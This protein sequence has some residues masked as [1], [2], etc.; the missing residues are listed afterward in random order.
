MSRWIGA[1]ASRRGP[2]DRISEHALR[3]QRLD[4]IRNAV[5]QFTYVLGLLI[6]GHE[7][8]DESTDEAV[9]AQLRRE[10]QP[11]LDAGD[12][13]RPDFGAF[14]DLRIEGE[15]LQASQPILATLEFDD[16]S[17]RET[18]QGRVVPARGRRLRVRMH[19]AIE[20]VRIIDCAVSEVTDRRG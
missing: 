14:G 18:A 11:F 5:E 6:A 13:M 2:A 8:P 4:H 9:T 7:A 12:A 3:E 10:L 20:P 1:I 15:L 17:V 19:I 16:R